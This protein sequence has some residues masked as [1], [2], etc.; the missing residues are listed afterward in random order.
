MNHLML[1]SVKS[2]SP[3]VEVTGLMGIKTLSLS[4]S[5]QL[6]SRICKV[7]LGSEKVNGGGGG[8]E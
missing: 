6:M 4:C 8:G 2:S 7:I 3:L 5:P 1:A